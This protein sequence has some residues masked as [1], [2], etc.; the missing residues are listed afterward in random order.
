MHTPDLILADILDANL[1]PL[2][3]LDAQTPLSYTQYLH[4][5][6][7]DLPSLHTIEEFVSG[8]EDYLQSPLQPLMDNLESIT[9]ETFE[10]DPV[11]YEKYQS[12]ILSALLDITPTLPP[13]PIKI[14]VVGAGRG[15]LVS[16][17]LRASR[18]ASR[19]VILYAVEKNPNAIVTL[20][21]MNAAAWG[22]SVEI[23][24]KDMRDLDKS[25]FG[26]A[27]EGSPLDSLGVDI[28]VSELLGS[29]GGMLFSI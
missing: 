25:H 20:H 5:L 9:Y 14:V 28:I 18:S 21:R 15:P 13:T 22:N 2:A 6:I 23:I 12:A 8:Y 26:K 24:C 1:K 27:D 3:A 16:C 10:R 4:H 11:K 7:K 17:A 29:F 19:P